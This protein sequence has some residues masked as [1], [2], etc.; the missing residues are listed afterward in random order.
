MKKL[1]FVFSPSE[2]DYIMAMWGDGEVMGEESFE[3]FS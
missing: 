3:C 1:G 2:I